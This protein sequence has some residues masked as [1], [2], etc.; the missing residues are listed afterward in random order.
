MPKAIVLS[1]AAA[2]VTGVLYLIPILFVL[3]DVQMLRD[4]ANGQPIGLLFKTVTGSAAGGFGL[5][6]LLLGMI[7]HI[8]PETTLILTLVDRYSFFRWYWC[9]DSC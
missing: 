9:F 7:L 3:P 4:V 5:L 6:F 1:V 8:N 2:G